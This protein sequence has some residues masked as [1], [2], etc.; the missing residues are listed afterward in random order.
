VR[1]SPRIAPALTLAAAALLLTA[2]GDTN[3]TSGDHDSHDENMMTTAPS[4]MGHGMD[5]GDNSPV[6]DDA[7]RIEVTATSFEFDPQEITVEAGEDIA[8]V[9][10]SDDILHDFTID[11]LDAHVAADAD[12]TAEGGFTAEE[13]GRYTY[14]CTVEGHRDEGMEGTLVVT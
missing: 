2:C 6:A 5:H 3:S 14:Y 7:L 9:L 11:E 12:E 8:I 4:S 13:P 1:R 10:T